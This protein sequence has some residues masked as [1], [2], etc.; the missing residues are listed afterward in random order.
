MA[1]GLL[2]LRVVVGGIFF[3]HGSQ[4]LLGWFGGPGLGG[5]RGW[6]GGI[7]FRAPAAMALLVACSESSGLLF[8]LGLF[9]PFVAV[10]LTATMIVAV[11]T[12]HWKNGF[13]VGKGGYEFN[14]ALAAGA[15]SVAMT[16]PGRF[17]L[18]RALGWDDNLSGA[19]WGVGVVVV[20][21][22]GA[23]F[24]LTALRRTPEPAPTS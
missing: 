21:A 9:T 12:T 24:V 6:L 17:S 14:L 3:A 18:D 13:F 15:V 5:V 11:A 2:L 20:A 19:W 23:A 16:G 4:K 10:A 1:Y 22:L 7:G 8:A